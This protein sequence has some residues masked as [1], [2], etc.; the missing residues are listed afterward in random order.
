[1]SVRAVVPRRARFLPE[2]LGALFSGIAARPPSRP[3][4]AAPG[5]LSL[6]GSKKR[7]AEGLLVWSRWVPWSCSPVSVCAPFIGSRRLGGHPDIAIRLIGIAP[8]RRSR[9]PGPS[10]GGAVSVNTPLLLGAMVSW[11]PLFFQQPS[12]RSLRFPPPAPCGDL[13]P[14]A[15]RR[16][17]ARRRPPALFPPGPSNSRGAY[18]AAPPALTMSI[19]RSPHFP[20]PD[21]LRSLG[22]PNQRERGGRLSY[23]VADGIN[24]RASYRLPRALNSSPALLVCLGHPI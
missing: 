7:A 6:L 5:A 14:G 10:T 17:V 13:F 11:S 12:L 22:I 15:F 2:S 19:Y 21:S 18:H 24:L 1:M 16:D 3:P 20:P 9:S 23:P 8:G 4:S